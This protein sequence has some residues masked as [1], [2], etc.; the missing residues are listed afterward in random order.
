MNSCV[1]DA[2]YLGEKLIHIWRKEGGEELLDQ[3]GGRSRGAR[4]GRPLQRG[5]LNS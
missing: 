2:I 3:A 1:R 4:Q 5:G